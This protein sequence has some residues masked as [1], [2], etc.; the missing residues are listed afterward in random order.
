MGQYDR[1][2]ATALRMVAQYGMVVTWEKPGPVTGTE[3]NPISGEPVEHSVSIVFLPSE[4][5]GLASMLS[6]IQGTEVPNGGMVGYMGAV[7]FVP[8]LTDSVLGFDDLPLYLD[9]KNG[10]ER[11]APSG[12]PILYILRFVR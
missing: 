12:V 9:P 11:L 6:A 2:I 3:A 10:I 7:D 5:N 8:E 1:A 4:A